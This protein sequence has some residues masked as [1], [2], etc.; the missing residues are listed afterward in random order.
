MAIP[1]TF[2]EV[3]TK[4]TEFATYFT[5]LAADGTTFP[6]SET[7]SG[8]VQTAWAKVYEVMYPLMQTV[9][10]LQVQAS[11]EPT[12]QVTPTVTA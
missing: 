6:S 11:V 9:K 5:A 12:A 8:Q 2:P 10:Q 3:S 7:M 1:S 4:M